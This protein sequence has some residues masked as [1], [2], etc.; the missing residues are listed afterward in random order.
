MTWVGIEPKVARTLAG[1]LNSFRTL[2]SWRPGGALGRQYYE[3]RQDYS[4]GSFV[5][6]YDVTQPQHC[7]GGER[8][9]LEPSGSP[10]SACARRNL[11]KNGNRTG[12]DKNVAQGYTSDYGKAYNLSYTFNSVNAL[13]AI[14]DG[15][16]QG[17]GCAVTCDA[18]GN[19]TQVDESQAGTGGSPQT[20]YLYSYFTYDALNRLTEHKTKAYV[21]GGT[22]AWVLARRT[23][24]YDA[25]G[26]LT[27]SGYRSYN[28]GGA[29]PGPTN[30]V[31]SYSGS[32]LVQNVST[33][34]QSFGAR[35][36]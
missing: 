11:N 22:N 12:Y 26:R 32:R 36:H 9:C 16:D 13:T 20:N 6:R 15:D 1:E 31:H 30:H 33:D 27:Q 24:A 35:W 7:S 25:L 2:Y 28:D 17:Y 23:H 4:A 19:I 5:N 14:S 21:A 18:N 29:D 34:G 8:L 3:E 10:S